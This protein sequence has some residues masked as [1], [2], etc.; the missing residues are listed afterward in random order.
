MKI[1]PVY[2]VLRLEQPIVIDG[3]WDKPQ[4]QNVQAVT[5]SN[6]MGEIPKYRPVVHA[7][8]MY[9]EENLFVIF[10][11]KDRYVR[12]LAKD[13]NGAVWEDA[14]IEFFFS[15]DAGLVQCYFNLEINCGGTPLM[16]Y[17]LIPSKEYNP[18]EIEDLK[19]IEIAH[20]LPPIIE[21]EMTE[22][23][24]WTIEYRIPLIILNKYS[25][26]TAAPTKGVEWQANFYKIAENNSNPHY[27][28]W[29]VVENLT[30][31]FHLPKFFGKLKFM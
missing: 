3:N 22:C 21:P 9:N 29:S 18:V 13:F 28:T 1:K 10:M 25:N 23:V 16:H 20:S 26:L 19:K 27:M 12:C 15:P 14:C 2:N 8:M 30:P 24:N 5:I 11:V 6:F 7:K 31:D 17:N 4:W